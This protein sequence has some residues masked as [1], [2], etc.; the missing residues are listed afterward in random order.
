MQRSVYRELEYLYELLIHKNIISPFIVIFFNFSMHCSLLVFKVDLLPIE[1]NFLLLH[2][3]INFILLIPMSNFG[4]LY[5]EIFTLHSVISLT[6]Q[7]NPY[8]LLPY[9]V[10]YTHSC[11]H[12]FLMMKNHNFIC[13]EI[14]IRNLKYPEKKQ[15]EDGQ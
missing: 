9:S 4:C 11:F 12:F 6:S 5:I 2:T 14:F 8:K 7:I 15:S 3:K 10:F 13:H 1:N